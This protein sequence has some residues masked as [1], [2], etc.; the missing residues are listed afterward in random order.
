M[1]KGYTIES[2]GCGLFIVVC[3]FKSL[4]E[5]VNYRFS[6]ISFVNKNDNNAIGMWKPKKLK[7]WNT[8]KKN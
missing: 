6:E 4:N 8:G 1:N 7:Q 5:I 3:N 2:I